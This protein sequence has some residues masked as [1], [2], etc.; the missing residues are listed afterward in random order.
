MGGPSYIPADVRVEPR[1]EASEL[2]YIATHHTN[3]PLYKHS[4]CHI[5]QVM[6]TIPFLTVRN[7]N[8]EISNNLRT[9][10][11]S[12]QNKFA[13]LI[14]NLR[15]RSNSK[16]QLS[17]CV[18]VCVFCL[19]NT[20]PCALPCSVTGMNLPPPSSSSPARH[21]QSVWRASAVVGLSWC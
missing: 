21:S 8:T 10:N 20:P 1:R 19:F 17:K 7:R 9:L 12:P 2:N 13:Y 11:Q 3:P 5:A 14:Y 15:I 4:L 18:C 6:N 16:F